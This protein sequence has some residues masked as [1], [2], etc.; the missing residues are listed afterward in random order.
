MYIYIYIYIYIKQNKFEK[1]NKSYRK[2]KHTSEIIHTPIKVGGCTY[3]KYAS[4]QTLHNG[5]R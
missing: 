5:P 3:A 2:N 1:F 4:C